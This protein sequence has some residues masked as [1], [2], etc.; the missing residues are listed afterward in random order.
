LHMYFMFNNKKVI[1][2]SK[3][4]E[5]QVQKGQAKHVCL[6]CTTM[7]G[8]LRLTNLNQWPRSLHQERFQE[9]HLCL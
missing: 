3:I 5:K 2:P 4:N 1:C 8:G 6:K 7:M 9:F